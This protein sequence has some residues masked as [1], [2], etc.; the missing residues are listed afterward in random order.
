MEQ[1]RASTVVIERFK[2]ALRGPLGAL[3]DVL[4]WA[5]IRPTCVLG[6]LVLLALGAPPWVTVLAFLLPYNIA[7]LAARV[8]GF[9]LG[10]RHGSAVASGLRG[11]P[12]A[13]FALAAQRSAA[14]LLGV[15]L[16][17]LAIGGLTGTTAPS[18]AAVVLVGAGLGIVRGSA[19]RGPALAGLAL[20]IAFGLVRGALA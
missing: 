20:L 11:A 17:I 7:H 16:P 3:G 10:L 6:A 19:I 13:R 5:G 14:F 1:D 4:F 12:L 9:R 18:I 2:G 15:L 8:W